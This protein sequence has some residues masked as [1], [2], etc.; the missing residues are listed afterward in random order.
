MFNAE[1]RKLLIEVISSWQ[2]WV[3][4][5]VL[6]LYVFLVNY[7]ARLYHRPSGFGFPSRS[8]SKPEAAAAGPEVD[9]LGLE[10][11]PTPKK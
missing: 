5:V 7:V 1:V 2:V 9:E 4:T 10:E 8:K 6:V 11:E 3:V